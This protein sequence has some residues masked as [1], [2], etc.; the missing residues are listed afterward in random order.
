MVGGE[1]V[2]SLAGEVVELSALAGG[3]EGVGGLTVVEVGFAVVG[4]AFQV[5]V[6]F[7]G[8]PALVVGG[9]VVDVAMRDRL[10]AAGGVLAVP[11]AHL[12]G[13]AQH[14]PEGALLGCGD[15]AVGAVEDERLHLGPGEV[16]HDQLRRD[17]GAVASS[18]S[19]STVA[20]PARMH[21]NGSGRRPPA[22]TVLARIAI[23]TRAPAIRSLVVR[24]TPSC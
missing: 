20:S 3:G 7:G 12:D 23:S 24:F 13:A 16:G 18:H 9:A 21:S 22:G 10:V 19:L 6:G 14:P 2:E 8:D 17:D 4:F 1:G 15:D 11:V 5:T